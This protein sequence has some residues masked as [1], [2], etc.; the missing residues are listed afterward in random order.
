MT[1]NPFFSEPRVTQMFGANPAYYSK[2]GLAGHE[3]IDLV[4][5]GA[6]WRVRAV[7]SGTVVYDDDQA[8]NR[9][10]GNHVRIKARD[11]RVWCYCH[12]S[13]N[14]VTLGQVI[15]EGDVIGTMG[16]TGTGTGAHLHL[17]T[18]REDNAGRRLF[19]DN[20]Y[21]GCENPHGMIV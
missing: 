16:N 9:A 14:V 8:K 11:G 18:Y 15:D 20:G 17:M 6:D 13:Q 5:T 4:P 10:Y 19:A 21:K 7:A 3:G 2:Y 12:L 1:H